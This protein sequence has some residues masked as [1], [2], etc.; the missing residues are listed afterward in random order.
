MAVG[1]IFAALSLAAYAQDYPSKSIKIIVPYPPGAGTD[2][3]ARMTAEKLQS[4]WGQPVMV[5]NRAGANGNIGAEAVFKSPP[6][7]Y[8]FLFSAPGPLVTSKSL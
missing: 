5:E 4:K 3:L 2:T 6:D 7:G 1:L 8:T